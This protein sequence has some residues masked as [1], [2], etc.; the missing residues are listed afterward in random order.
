MEKYTPIIQLILFSAW[1]AYPILNIQCYGIGRYPSGAEEEVKAALNNWLKQ[2]KG[3]VEE[4]IEAKGFSNRTNPEQAALTIISIIEGGMMISGILDKPSLQESKRLGR[5][6]STSTTGT[7][8]S[9]R[10]RWTTS[11]RQRARASA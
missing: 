3:L 11:R 6:R 8:T 2:L 9:A 1:R 4:G 5:S 10:P 7:R